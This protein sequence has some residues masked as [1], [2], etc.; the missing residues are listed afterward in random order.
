MRRHGLSI[1]VVSASL[2]AALPAVA[3]PMLLATGTLSQASDLSGLTGTLENGTAANQLG[4]IGSGLAWAG[5]SSFV[6]VPDRGPNA[7]SY[8]SAVDDTT[9]FIAR[10]EN[11]DLALTPNA[12]NTAFTLT[13]TLQSTTLLYSPAPLN[14]GT[15]AGLGTESNGAPLRNGAPAQN[16]ASQFYFTGRSD[17][18]GPGTSGNVSNAR[19]DPEGV[20]VSRDGRSVFVSD[21]Y[22]PYVNQFDRSSGALLR[23]YA[24]PANLYISNLNPRGSVEIS[25]NTVGRIANKGMEGL[26]ITPDGTMLVGIM[27]ASLEQDGA[28]PK[29]LRIVTIDVATGVTHEYAYLLTTGT[30]VSEIT[31][32][33]DHEFLVDERDGKGLGDG[34]N[35]AVKQVFKINLTGATDI[36]ALNATAAAAVAVAKTL[37]VDLVTLLQAAGLTKA[38]IP[39]KIEGLAFGQDVMVNVSG[40]MTV[41]HVL[42]VANDNDFAAASGPNT[43]YAVGLTDADLAGSV[44]T[45]Q[46]IPEPASLTML[47]AG[48]MAM[49]AMMRRHRR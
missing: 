12:N 35:A 21:E 36:T 41:R 18:Y 38:Q 1:L 7:T 31:A 37:T 44:F 24:L 48:M 17:N 11:L 4:G 47:A 15:G 19:L 25:G 13:P 5:G 14:Y 10:L 8:N 22:G 27:Q 34:T 39:A 20:R 49:G 32:L 40:V 30:G 42:Y 45:Q 16:T 2:L 33:N 9:S 6:A 3:A 43:F 26:A 29:L 28:S 23:S 46:T